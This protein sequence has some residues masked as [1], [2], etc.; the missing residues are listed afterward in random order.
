MSSGEPLPDDTLRSA[1]ERLGIE[2][3]DCLGQTEIHIFMNPDP[4][5]K[6]GS[7]GLP[8]DGHVVTVLNDEG[9]EAKPHEIGHL[10][11]NAGVQTLVIIIIKIV[12]DAALRIC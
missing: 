5:K 6:L 1:R 8:L 3:Y 7:L 9:G 10:V 2:I 4:V 11:I 12:G